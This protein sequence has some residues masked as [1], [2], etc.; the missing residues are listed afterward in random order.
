MTDGR[1]DLA[2]P[3]AESGDGRIWPCRVRNQVI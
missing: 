3:R 2:V 1:V